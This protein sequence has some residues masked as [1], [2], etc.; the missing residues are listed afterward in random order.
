MWLFKAFWR[1]LVSQRAWVEFSD[2]KGWNVYIYN[3]K[4]LGQ[5]CLSKSS[6]CELEE[7]KN[8]TW[9]PWTQT[10]IAH[11]TTSA[12]VFHVVGHRKKKLD[13]WILLTSRKSQ[14]DARSKKLQPN[15]KRALSHIGFFS[16][17]FLPSNCYCDVPTWLL[18]SV[19]LQLQQ[20]LLW[21]SM[22]RSNV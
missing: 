14:W 20:L 10:T 18:H 9:R 16:Y 19:W 7:R 13:S 6:W 11:G 17:V 15:C 8:H 2:A 21:V 3:Q 12:E 1:I 5:M 4:T 22:S